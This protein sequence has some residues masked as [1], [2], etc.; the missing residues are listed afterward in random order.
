MDTVTYPDPIVK[1]ELA[2]WVF[3][4]IDVSE[5]KQAAEWFDVAALP[6]ALAVSA[7]MKI[8]ARIAGFVEPAAFRQK[9]ADTRNKIK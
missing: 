2:R 6:V 9:L 1:E 3:L 4:K 7:D 5:H 8:H